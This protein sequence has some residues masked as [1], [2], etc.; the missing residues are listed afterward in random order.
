MSMLKKTNKLGSVKRCVLVVITALGV[1][2]ATPLH[3]QTGVVVN[4]LLTRLQHTLITVRDAVGEEDLPPL[5]KATMNLKST[6]TQRGG[7][8][9]SL[10]VIHLGA[11]VTKDS[12]LEISLE[13]GPPKDSD[14]SPVSSSVDP[15]AIAIIE[16]LT[17]V[18]KAEKNTPPLHL[19]KLTAVVRFGIRFDTEGGSGFKILPFE[20]EL[21]ADLKSETVHELILEFKR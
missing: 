7:G 6:F 2:T 15:L 18:R 20:A 3:A 13:V 9:V 14:R 21:G 19:R 8:N 12:V 1:L 16:S 11:E 10:V 5:S 17:A 4:E